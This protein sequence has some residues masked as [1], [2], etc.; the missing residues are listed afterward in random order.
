MEVKDNIML[1]W[2]TPIGV[3]YNDN[4]YAIKNDL[5]DFFENY[6][7][8]NPNSKKGDENINL[9]ESNYNIH[10]LN[11]PSYEKLMF[12]LQ[13]LLRKFLKKQIKN[14]KIIIS[15]TLSI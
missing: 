13:N 3:F 8:N 6:K 15:I 4:H 11:N 5:I 14:F 1:L 10:K 9:Y 2:P 7:N 12:F